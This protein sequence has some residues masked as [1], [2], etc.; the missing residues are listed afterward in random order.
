M[1]ISVNI[2]INQSESPSESKSAISFIE[3]LS[4][5]NHELFH[6]NLL[7]FLAGQEPSFFKGLFDCCEYDTDYI[8]REVDNMDFC[9]FEKNGDKKVFIL[10]NKMKSLPL[11]SQLNE[12]TDNQKKKK[13]LSENCKFVLLTLIPPEKGFKEKLNEDWQILSYKWLAEK[14]AGLL[15]SGVKLNNSVNYLNS[16]LLDYLNYLEDV[17]RITHEAKDFVDKPDLTI[18]E[19]Y[20]VGSDIPKWKKQ[21]I[22]KT[23]FYLLVEKLAQEV[24]INGIKYKTNY[25]PSGPN[26]E[27]LIYFDSHWKDIVS[28]GKNK[29]DKNKKELELTFFMIHLQDKKLNRGFRLYNEESR[30]YKGRKKKEDPDGS[31]RSNYLEQIWDAITS[32]ETNEK[33]KRIATELDLKNYK[34][35]P[36]YAFVYDDVAIPYISTELSDEVKFS[37]IFQIMVD[38]IKKV[39][40]ICGYTSEENPQKLNSTIRQ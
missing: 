9:L 3:Y 6:S 37:E 40:K 33:G 5:G 15:K 12:Y 26:L 19:L 21:L 34:E 36:K 35:S 4:G 17:D 2:T 23:R 11:I 1:N 30:K 10:E 13:K 28:K 31:S 29:K 20:N 27:A 38:E 8:G 16:F 22:L 25:S 39:A 14:I 18:K 7:A 32:E 24:G